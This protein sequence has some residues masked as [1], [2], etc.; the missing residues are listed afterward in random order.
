MYIVPYWSQTCWDYL[1]LKN[2]SIASI[3]VVVGQLPSKVLRLCQ[4]GQLRYLSAIAEFQAENFETEV[5]ISTASWQKLFS[6]ESMWANSKPRMGIMCTKSEVGKDRAPPQ[7]K[8]KQRKW[9]KGVGES[10]M[11]MGV[12][13]KGNRVYETSHATIYSDHLW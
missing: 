5:L 2:H 3:P 12:P 1:P 7:P 6:F 9:R 10:T 8:C 13:R 11:G 4:E